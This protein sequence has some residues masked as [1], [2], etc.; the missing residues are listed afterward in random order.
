MVMSSCC[1]ASLV[2]KPCQ[3]P[4]EDGSSV[5]ITVGALEAYGL[6]RAYPYLQSDPEN[7]AHICAA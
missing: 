5:A 2:Y 3:L 6:L 7:S 1:L 4:T